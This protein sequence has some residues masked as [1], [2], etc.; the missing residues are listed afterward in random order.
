MTWDELFGKVREGLGESNARL[1]VLGDLMTK[2][3]GEGALLSEKQVDIAL[4]SLF[5]GVSNIHSAVEHMSIGL[6]AVVEAMREASKSQE[7]KG[8]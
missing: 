1:R 7:V 6:D 3:D 4:T 8:G 2:T 5:L